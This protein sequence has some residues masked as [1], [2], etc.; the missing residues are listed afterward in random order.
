MEFMKQVLP[1]FDNPHNP[2]CVLSPV[3]PPSEYDPKLYLVLMGP[4]L[5]DAVDE[6]G[7]WLSTLVVVKATDE[8]VSDLP[9]VMEANELVL[10]QKQ[11]FKPLST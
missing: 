11:K 9:D 4:K 6:V 7:F 10:Y 8:F 2:G 3:F 5:V 1:K